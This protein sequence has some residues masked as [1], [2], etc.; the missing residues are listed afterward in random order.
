MKPIYEPNGKAKEKLAELVDSVLRCLPWGEISSHTAEDVAERIIESG[1]LDN[2]GQF[3][4]IS[5]VDRL[6]EM[7]H[8][9]MFDPICS[10]NYEATEG[11]VLA[12]SKSEGIRM[13]ECSRDDLGIWWS[14]EGGTAYKDVT[15]WMPLPEP[16]KGE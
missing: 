8:F 12:H 13:L 15:H 10:C 2:L 5:V 6:P 7:K 3:K 1:L 14:E 11:Y 4:W 16:P 9:P